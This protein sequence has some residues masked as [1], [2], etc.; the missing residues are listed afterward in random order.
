[1]FGLTHMISVG[2]PD[3]DLLVHS[4]DEPEILDQGV[5]LVVLGTLAVNDLNGRASKQT[6]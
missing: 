5:H 6:S 4:M 3:R 1:M 2:Q